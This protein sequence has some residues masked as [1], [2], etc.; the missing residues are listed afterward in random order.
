[1][2]ALLASEWTAALG[3]DGFSIEAA[4]YA[5]H[6]HRGTAQ[7]DQDDPGMLEPEAQQLLIGWTE[8]LMSGQSIPQGPLTARVRQAAEWMTR[9][10]GTT[11]R[12]FAI[13]FCREVHTYLSKPDSARRAAARRAVADAIA[14]TQPKVI[15]AHSLG[16]VVTYETLW[17]HP[18][19]DIDLW[20]TVGSPLAMPTI[21]LPRL[22]P[23]TGGAPPRVRHW[24]NVADVGDIVAIPRGGLR[25]HF[26]GV[27][28]DLEV[29]IHDVDFHRMVNYLRN[30][31]VA[32]LLTNRR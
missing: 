11:A 19:H 6:L 26:D 27:E 23:A 25:G 17:A 4:Y 1:M 8:Q 2:A 5:H 22:E 20:V 18:D 13:A 24:I 21:I 3:K 32:A 7:S 31:D 15:V 16:S 28:K 9:R 14:R 30:A 12:L 29:V 10:F